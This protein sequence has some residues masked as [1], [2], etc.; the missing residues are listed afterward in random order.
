MKAMENL[1][2]LEEKTGS[3][4]RVPLAHL[5]T[6]IERLKR[7]SAGFAGID[8]LIKRDDATGL[9]FGGNK[10]RKLEFIL[11]DALAKNADTIITWAGVQSN[12]CRQTAA[13]AARLGLRSIVVLFRKPGVTTEPDGNLL[14]DRI[15][16]ARVEIVEATAETNMMELSGVADIIGALEEEE[17]SA[18]RVPYVASIGG[19]RVEG[20][21]TEP[22]GALGYVEAF[23]E[24]FEQTALMGR[25]PDAV[26]HATGSGSTQ[27]GLL[28]GAKILSPATKIIGISV[29]EEEETMS[30]YVREISEATLDLLGADQRLEEGDVIILPEYLQ[31]GYG[32][33][34]R[35][36]AE[37]IDL[38]ATT[39]GILLDPV[40]TGKAMSGLIDLLG[41]GTFPSGSTVLF[42]HSGGTP[43]LFPYRQD[44]IEHLER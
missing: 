37:A 8:L 21:M 17:Q 2:H 43:A 13:A 5:P 31:E 41:K 27:A 16:N 19:S 33:M 20:S 3:F 38:V 9:A 12:W 15:F 22:L 10:A 23:A 24:I 32:V 6:P 30:R 26:V 1:N 14:L 7:L 29:S 34:T 35:E 18:G 44:I 4:A 25:V 42:L 11:A 28:V 36:V 39:E 40:Y